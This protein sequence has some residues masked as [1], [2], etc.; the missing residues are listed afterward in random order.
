MD[1]TSFM[2]PKTA[3]ALDAIDPI[4]R[5][6]NDHAHAGVFVHALGLK[7][8]NHPSSAGPALPLKPSSLRTKIWE[9]SAV[10]HCSIIG[11]C[12]TVGEL[13]TLLRK[14]NATD[15]KNPSDHDL[16]TIAVSAAGTRDA[17]SKEINKALDR[18]H[19]LT[20]SRFG[21]ANSTEDL[22]SYW[23]EAVRGGDIPGAYWALLTHP[24][25][26]DEV[27]RH[28]FGDLHMLSHLV[29]AANRADI[30]RLRALEEEKAALEEKLERQQRRLRDDI[31]SRDLKIRELGEALAASIEARHVEK[32]VEDSASGA[33]VFDHL[34]IDLRKKL[35]L[36]VRRRERAEKTTRDLAETTA[37]KKHAM[38][39]VEQELVALRDELRVAESALAALQDGGRE[40]P[41]EEWGLAGLTV[42]Y[43]GG[44]P[45]QIARLRSLFE[46]ASA[47]LVHHDGGIEQNGDLLAGLVSKA[48]I[49]VFPIDCISHAA[50]QSLKRLCRQ[51]GKPFVPLRTSGL[52][53]F[54]SG[55]KSQTYAVSNTE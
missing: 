33:S 8:A 15:A 37:L 43:V 25:A 28:A 30:H 21:K 26:T 47:S 45:H 14:S 7:P 46:R 3:N 38:E 23:D 2:L 32:Q 11:T 36:E 10:L 13:R 22:R 17:L 42:L 40:R 49:A 54:L 55:I 4:E 18:R 29:G 12:L 20:I 27:V 48:D 39:T 35:D 19:R 44:R 34:L 53:S 50:A 6:I 31:V 5:M 9:L 52:A 1:K 41:A 16:H 51:A 24:L